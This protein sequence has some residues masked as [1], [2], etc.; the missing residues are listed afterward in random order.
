MLM[1]KRG[2]QTLYNQIVH[3]VV[4]HLRQSGFSKVKANCPEYTAPGKVK[5][6]E[7]DE[8]VVPDIV[9]EREGSVYVFEIETGKVLEPEAVKNRWHLLSVHA[10]RFNGKF[11]LVTPENTADSLQELADKLDLRPEFLRL[12]GI[13]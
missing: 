1:S 11:Y 6:D 10:R 3:S 7:N 12:S 5:W 2:D 9:G 13:A 8:G 4:G